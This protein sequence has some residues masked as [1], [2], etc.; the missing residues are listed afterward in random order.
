MRPRPHA[1]LILVE[2][3]FE[4]LRT[5]RTRYGNGFT[6]VELLVVI[7]I[8]AV[9]IALLI[10]AIQAA[11]ESARR[12]AC[13]NHLRQLGVALHSFHDVSQ[14]YPIGCL[15]RRPFGST[16]ERQLSW[17]VFLL[18]HIEKSQTVD[19][20]DTTQPFDSP[21]NLQAAR[22]IVPVFLCPSTKN[23]HIT[24]RSGRTDDGLGATDYGGLFGALGPG[25]LPGNGVM[26]FDKTVRMRDVTDGLGQT[27]I[28]AEDTGR[29]T[30][31][32]AQWANGQ[33]IFDVTTGINLQQHNEIYSDHSQGA[34]ALFCD[35]TVRLLRGDTERQVLIAMCTRADG[36]QLVDKY[37]D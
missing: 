36:D 26:L 4:E 20:F 25:L 31:H 17:N 13:M 34:F 2:R 19:R 7:A 1:G 9:L 15:E 16:V 5:I 18:P 27:I 8:V 14:R 28:V 29:G 21:V 22:R 11:R 37:L 35:A 24:R 23:Y 32:D 33:N 3:P 10:P 6:L 12:T 30:L